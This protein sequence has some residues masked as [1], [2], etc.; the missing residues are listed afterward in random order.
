MDERCG[1][2]EYKETVDEWAQRLVTD[3][4][5]NSAAAKDDTDDMMKQLT[6]GIKGA[7]CSHFS[8]ISVEGK[9]KRS[10]KTETL[11]EKKQQLRDEARRLKMQ[12]FSMSVVLRGWQCMATLQR[13]DKE[14]RKSR[15]A[16]RR[17]RTAGWAAEVH[18][19]RWRG[20]DEEYIR[21]RHGIRHKRCCWTRKIENVDRRQKKLSICW[22]RWGRDTT[23][24]SG[25]VH[26]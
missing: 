20:F 3:P 12:P 7:T 23:S 25:D 8:K 24:K 13:K 4:R 21:R 6:E 15:R 2:E 10:E 18:P 1:L 5:W 26:L 14:L 16:D 19:A 9:Y 17:A 11:Y 22:I